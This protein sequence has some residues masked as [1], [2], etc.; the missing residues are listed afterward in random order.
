MQ[1]GSNIH[2]QMAKV[3]IWKK[4]KS[5]FTFKIIKLKFVLPD[6]LL[7]RIV[8]LQAGQT[9]KYLYP[10]LQKKSMCHRLDDQ[11]DS[12]SKLQKHKALL[13]FVASSILT[14]EGLQ[15]IYPKKTRNENTL[16]LLYQK[17]LQLEYFLF[18]TLKI[19]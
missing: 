5:L 12:K 9:R 4:G 18:F 1:A 6:L 15:K 8:V 10:P 16:Y 3:Y 13:F 11:S 19:W 7:Q 14:S 2:N 17:P